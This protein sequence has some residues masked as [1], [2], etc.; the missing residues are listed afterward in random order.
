[1]VSAIGIVRKQQTGDDINTW[2]GRCKCEREHVILALK[3]DGSV[4]RVQCRTCDS[5]HLFRAAKAAST[6]RARASREK[7]AATA[8]DAGPAKEYSMQA[9]FRVGDRIS[10]PRFGIGTVIEQRQSKIDVKFGREVRVLVHAG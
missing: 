3:P 8:E 1:M 7:S 4:E 6:G 10:H 2:C 5:N 9:R